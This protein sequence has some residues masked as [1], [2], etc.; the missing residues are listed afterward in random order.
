M[1]C[2]QRWLCLLPVE[3]EGVRWPPSPERELKQMGRA[4]A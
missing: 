3:G 2:S 1:P 4:L